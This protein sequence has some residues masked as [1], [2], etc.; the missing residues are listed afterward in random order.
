[1]LSSSL[2]ALASRFTT[3]SGLPSYFY[4][5]WGPSAPLT[6]GTYEALA[7]EEEKERNRTE[8]TLIGEPQ[9]SQMKIH[10]ETGLVLWSA[11]IPAFMKAVEKCS[12]E[13]K[14]EWDQLRVAHERL[15]EWAQSTRQL[16][17]IPEHYQMVHSIVSLLLRSIRLV[18]RVLS[19]P[20][21]QESLIQYRCYG[22]ICAYMRWLGILISKSDGLMERYAQAFERATLT[23]AQQEDETV[24]EVDEES[25]GNDDE[26]RD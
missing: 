26:G 5:F 3:R 18:V 1:V 15:N 22:L 13:A 19:G 12:D 23:P 17:N 8:K 24:D 14:K 11:N 4:R 20:V 7:K 21:T 25:D 2:E 16:L 10:L 9:N 6:G